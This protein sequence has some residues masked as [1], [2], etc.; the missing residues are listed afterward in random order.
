MKV[1]EPLFKR[2]KGKFTIPKTV[3]DTIPIKAV[4]ADGIFL[5]G[6]EQ[7]SKTYQFTDINYSVASDDDQRDMFLDYSAFLNSFDDEATTKI[8]IN[9]RSVNR[10]D[11]EKE[12]VIPYMQD[13]LDGYRKEYNDM[14]VDKAMGSTSIVQEK[15]I[16]VTVHKDSYE[17]AKAYFSR[18]ETE[19]AAR[20]KKLGSKLIDFD[21]NDRLHILHDFYRIDEDEPFN[22]DLNQVNKKGHSFKDTICPDSFEF[23][24]DYFRMGDKYG[25]VIFLREYA[26]GISDKF[27]SKLTSMNKN[28]MLSIDV[29]PIP[30]HKASN[31]V[32]K[33]LLGIN[34]EITNWKRKQSSNGNYGADVP[35]DMAARKEKAEDLLHDINDRDQRM[36]L[37]ILTMVITADSMEQLNMD[38]KSIYMTAQG[39]NC[40]MG[41]LTFQQYDALKTVLPLGVRDIDCLRTLTSEALA[42]LMP[43]RVQDI[44]HKNGVYMGVNPI[45]KNL[46]RVD[47]GELLNGNGFILGV[48]GGGKSFAAKQEMI[49]YIL[50][51]GADIIAI[52]PE[53][54]YSPIVKA[55]GGEVIQISP[56]SKYHINPLDINK[57]YSDNANPIAFKSDFMM[58]L[59]QQI[60]GY[61]GI[62]PAIESIVDR[63]TSIV[64]NDY[65]SKGYKGTVPT[66][67][68]F[69]KVV[70][71][72]PEPEA[73]ELALALE[74]FT[75]GNLNT[76]A[77][78]TNVDVDNRFICYDILD[79]G[80]KLMPVGMLIILDSIFNR[81]TANRAKGKKTYIF[82]DEI[83]LLFQ[84]EYS[85][86]FLEVL[87]KRVRKYGA[88]ATGI[89][90]NVED[91]LRSPTARTMLAN[92]ELVVMLNQAATDRIQLAELL[93]I[94]DEELRYITNS[95]VG[96]GL[97]KIG[98]SLVPFENKFPKNS[99]YKLMSTKPGEE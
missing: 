52:D 15:Y 41:K 27:V 28:L 12:L 53:R 57:D 65:I 19:F 33:V 84:Y 18:I 42:V 64:L 36:F 63:C 4:Y 90:Q 24:R 97:L 62:S 69:R 26:S 58:S 56:T 83:Y 75:E 21:V 25:R 3:Q 93:G 34:T 96:H 77:Q 10:K 86:N 82:I 95:E 22:F 68:D 46:I 78:Q 59:C 29:E 45:S 73:K 80:K 74:R 2:N 88:Y 6:D 38:T 8:T 91:L 11:I 99:L 54:E 55:T 5:V 13:N 16:T 14:V 71:E 35:Y 32:E 37:C 39:E 9:N 85:A 79:L 43:F 70:L 60:M 72:Q 47:R 40:Q 98:S 61:E 48:S 87:W 23:K 76:F 50:S 92:S 94:S 17:E 44:K 81:V 66:L 89:T 51:T 31:Q 30:T 49:N 7:Y 1:L 67:I 20:L